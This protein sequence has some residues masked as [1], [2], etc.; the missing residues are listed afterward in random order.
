M[1]KAETAHTNE[2][3]VLQALHAREIAEK[4][5]SLVPR[6]DGQA[7]NGR[8]L[9]DGSLDEDDADVASYVKKR[10]RDRR[11]SDCE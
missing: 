2:V 7:L 5:N 1:A 3:A 10:K 6:H 8:G 9:E 4:D 11:K